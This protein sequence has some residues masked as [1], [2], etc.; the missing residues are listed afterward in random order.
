MKKHLKADTIL[1]TTKRKSIFK[2]VNRMFS[3][4][5]YLMMHMT[6]KALAHS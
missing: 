1:L 4:A 6:R 3:L 5:I 2:E